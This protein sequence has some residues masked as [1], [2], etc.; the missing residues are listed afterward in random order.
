MGL[1]AG[2]VV[3]SANGSHVGVVGDVLEVIAKGGS[4]ELIVQ[5]EGK[6]FLVLVQPEEC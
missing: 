5:R 6:T 4:V 3:T 1:K 2:D